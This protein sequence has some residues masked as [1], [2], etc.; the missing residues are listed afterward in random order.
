MEKEKLVQYCEMR[1]EVRNLERRIDQLRKQ[2]EMVGDVVQ[3]GYKGHAKIYGLDLNRR[4]KLDLYEKKLQTFYDKLIGEINEI[5][6]EIEKIDKSEI[7]QILRY[8]YIDNKSWIQIQI[9]MRL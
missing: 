9:E 5:E 4:Y 8:K 6:E 3:N 1:K 7:R 2:S